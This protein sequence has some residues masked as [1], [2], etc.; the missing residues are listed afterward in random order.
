MNTKLFIRTLFVSKLHPPAMDADYLKTAV[1]PTLI[2]GI[3]VVLQTNP[4]DPIEFLGQ[5]LVQSAVEQQRSS[6][7]PTKEPEAAAAAPQ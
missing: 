6:A 3:S 1:G 5:Y 7:K 4:R 2:E